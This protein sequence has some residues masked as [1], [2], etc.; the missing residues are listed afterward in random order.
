M[1]RK[2]KVVKNYEDGRIKRRLL[3]GAAILAVVTVLAVI[4]GINI[5]DEY[6]TYKS[7]EATIYETV[8]SEQGAYVLA[9]DKKELLGKMYAGFSV[10]AKESGE[11]IYQCPDLYLVKEL[12]EIKWGEEADSIVVVEKAGGENV[13]RRVGDTWVKQ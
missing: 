8:E 9:T 7:G 11:I 2:I 6:H 3:Y 13:Y 4:V 10:K 5:Y 12:F 1:N